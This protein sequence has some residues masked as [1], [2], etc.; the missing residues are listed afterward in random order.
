MVQVTEVV[1][2][3]KML[4]VSMVR[5]VLDSRYVLKLELMGCA[6]ELDVRCERKR[7]VKDDSSIFGLS[8]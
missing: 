3:N 4:T 7:G 2:W 8:N 5:S 1:A 6:D